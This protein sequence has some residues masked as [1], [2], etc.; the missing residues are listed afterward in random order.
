MSLRKFLLLPITC[1]YFM[2]DIFHA[3]KKHV[4]RA[5]AQKAYCPS[6]EGKETDIDADYLQ[7]S[8]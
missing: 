2:A 5:Q 1:R 3:K 8:T 7:A 4:T 6:I